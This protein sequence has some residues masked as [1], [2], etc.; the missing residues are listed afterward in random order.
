MKN[1]TKSSITLPPKELALVLELKKSLKAKSKVEVIRQGLLKLKE[2]F[3]RDALRAQF[4]DASNKVR[5]STME[6]MSELDALV[7]EGLNKK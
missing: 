3:D 4:A 2:G 1:N 7:S 5:T 6:E